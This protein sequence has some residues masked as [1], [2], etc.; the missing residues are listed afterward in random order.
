M[1]CVFAGLVIGLFTCTIKA[2]TKLNPPVNKRDLSTGESG[3]NVGESAQQE[4]FN[5][6]HRG[7]SDETGEAHRSL[8]TCEYC[9]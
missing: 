1:S 3:E 9:G 6:A 7:F 4:A 8:R 2:A 5:M